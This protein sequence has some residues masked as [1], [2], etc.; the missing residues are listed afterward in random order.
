MG[1]IMCMGW[2]V[3]DDEEKVCVC[4]CVRER[5]GLIILSL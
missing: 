3:G 4:V 5:G 1:V 2:L